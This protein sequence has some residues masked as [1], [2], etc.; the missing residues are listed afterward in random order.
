MSNTAITATPET[1]NEVFAIGESIEGATYNP[2][3]LPMVAR[4]IVDNRG[5]VGKKAERRARKCNEYIVLV[6]LDGTS[7]VR[8]AAGVLADYGMKAKTEFSDKQA[9]FD[10][11]MKFKKTWGNP[12]AGSKRAAKLSDADLLAEMKRRGLTA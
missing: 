8:T 12:L 1:E 7:K 10:A 4:F 2:R 5:L 3:I 9:A 6:Q 11:A